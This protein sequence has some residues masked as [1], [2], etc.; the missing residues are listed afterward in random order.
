MLG[1]PVK[2]TDFQVELFST[3]LE[4]EGSQITKS[5]RP[6][7]GKSEGLCTVPR[8]SQPQRITSQTATAS[9]SSSCETALFE[10][11]LQH[12]ARSPSRFLRNHGKEVKA[13]AACESNQDKPADDIAA[14][15]MTI[16]LVTLVIQK[17]RVRLTIFDRLV[18]TQTHT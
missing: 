15:R 6:E 12:S 18:L 14:T 7:C 10:K 4:P 5:A 16:F 1:V 11:P 9:T 13:G 2:R 3:L 17:K 8:C